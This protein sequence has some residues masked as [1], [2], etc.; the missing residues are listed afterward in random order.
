VG[1]GGKGDEERSGGRL[2]MVGGLQVKDQVSHQHTSVLRPKGQS[3]FSGGHGPLW[4]SFYISSSE[5]AMAS[6]RRALPNFYY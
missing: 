5:R 1:G 4:I 3:S 2:S 6:L